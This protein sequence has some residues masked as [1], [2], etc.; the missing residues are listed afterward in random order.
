M[1]GYLTLSNKGIFNRFQDFMSTAEIEDYYVPMIQ[2]SKYEDKYYTIP[3]AVRSL[4]LFWNK[5]L[6]EEAG[7]DP[8]APPETWDELVDMGKKMTI[9]DG[10]DRYEQAGFA[11]NIAAQGQ[12]VIPQVLLRQWGVEPYSEDQRTVQWNS[13]PEAVE[14]FKF[15]MDMTTEH[16]IGDADFMETPVTSFSSGRTAMVIDGS[17]NI[18]AYKENNDF[19]WGVTTLPVREKGGLES[20]FGSYW[21]NA[22]TKDVSGEKLEASQKF[23]EFLI[24]EETQK[25]WLENVGEL[26]AAASLA[27]DEEISSDPIYAPF[28]E[29]LEKAHATPFVHE[30]KERDIVIHATD[31]ILL[32]NADIEEA[33]NQMVEELQEVRDEFYGE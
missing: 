20:N 13:K 21:T 5:E 19:E 32:E 7:L 10:D 6:F 9:R 8:E 23:L 25:G 18:A 31:K 14:A 30:E 15:W 1:V 33:F 4:A 24:S 17:F 28:I 29:G 27:D 11:W 2:T 12:H 3:I 22:I 16:K 26:P